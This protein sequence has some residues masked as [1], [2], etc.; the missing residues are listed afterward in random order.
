MNDMSG[1][2]SNGDAAPDLMLAIASKDK[3][4]KGAPSAPD[5]VPLS[6]LNM[7]DD[8][9]QM[10]AP[11][12]GDKVQY[13]VEGTVENITGDNAYIDRTSINGQPVGE[14]DGQSE[15]DAGDQGGGDSGD[16]DMSQLQ[17]MAQGTQLQ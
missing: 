8:S 13:T 4:G 2:P 16:G 5:C 6:A 11:E 15:P 17:Q 9:E 12:V 3:P 14:E 1:A 7:P 10:Q